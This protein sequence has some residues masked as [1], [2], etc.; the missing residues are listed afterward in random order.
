MN[1]IAQP[2]INTQ[3]RFSMIDIDYFKRVNDIYGHLIGDQV[4]QQISTMFSNHFKVIRYDW[5]L[6]RRRICRINA[7]NQSGEWQGN[8]GAITNFVTDH[9]FATDKGEFQ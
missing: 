1:L 5:S 9:P 4:L 6:W 8:C 7:G 2:G 3:L